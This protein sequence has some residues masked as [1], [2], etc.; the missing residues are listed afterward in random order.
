[1]S[2]SLIQRQSTG[3][4]ARI[5]SCSARES[6]VKAEAIVADFGLAVVGAID[7][8]TA[9]PVSSVTVATTARQRKGL[10]IVVHPVRRRE[11]ADLPGV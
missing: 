10:F 5:A 4:D 2:R 6:G 8:P 3:V 1:M 11:A 7:S 9:Q